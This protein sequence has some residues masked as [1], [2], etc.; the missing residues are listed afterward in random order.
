MVSVSVPPRSFLNCRIVSQLHPSPI[1]PYPRLKM[2]SSTQSRSHLNPIQA[3]R[4]TFLLCLSWILPQSGSW[5]LHLAYIQVTSHLH[6]GPPNSILIPSKHH[7][8]PIQVSRCVSHLYPG[9]FST[10][11][12][13]LSS[14]LVPYHPIHVSRCAAQLNPGP[15]STPY[16]SCDW[17]LISIRAPRFNRFTFFP[18]LIWI[19]PPSRS[20][21]LHLAYIQQHL[22]YFRVC[23]IAY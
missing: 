6:P 15:I 10:G 19:S 21:Y 16:R 3:L 2:C 20:V 8:K 9:H 13:Y 5:Y 12:L 11:G 14:I 7:L 17:C 18:C 4:F 23:H 22:T 1:S